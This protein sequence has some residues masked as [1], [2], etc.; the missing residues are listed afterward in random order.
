VAD[1][2]RSVSVGC[3]LTVV[4]LPHHFERNEK[5]AALL[6]PHPL[7][8]PHRFDVLSKNGD[9]VFDVAIVG[10]EVDDCIGSPR[11]RAD[12][13]IK[14]DRLVEIGDLDEPATRRIDAA[15]KVVAPGF[16]DVH[17]QDDA[18]VAVRRA[19]RR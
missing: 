7:S 17:N 10:G 5:R 19:F 3:Q 6:C 14:S 4:L 12:V 18:Q 13:G 16:I 1:W 15:G 11:R 2:R 9:V 8:R